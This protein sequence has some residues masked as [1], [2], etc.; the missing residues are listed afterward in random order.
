LGAGENNIGPRDGLAAGICYR[1][2]NRNG[3]L[4]QVTVGCPQLCVGSLG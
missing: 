2:P 3:G 1:A 4:H